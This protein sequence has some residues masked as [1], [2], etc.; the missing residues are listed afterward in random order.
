[1]LVEKDT[2]YLLHSKPYRENSL[3][4]YVLTEQHGKVSFVV[5]GVKSTRAGKS[6][7][8]SSKTALLQPCRPLTLSYR[9]KD[10]LST[11][12]SIEL[13]KAGEIPTINHFM[14]YQY[15]HELLLTLLPQHHSAAMI[16]SAYENFLRDLCNE[17]PHGAL[18]LLE[19]SILD[20]F[21]GLESLYSTP[22]LQS[23]INV[24]VEYCLDNELGITPLSANSAGARR[25]S[26]ENLSAFN[27]LVNTY[28]SD[29]HSD[30]HVVESHIAE[31]IA[32]GA[33]PV[34]AFFIARLLNGKQLK[35]RN[36]YREL[37]EM[38][39]L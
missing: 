5:N 9:L 16:F 30:P 11:M 14:L 29:L 20:Y 37:Q 13:E 38:K 23:H 2:A 22:T 36:I 25:I 18:R 28:Q 34:S 4:A 12:T 3:L 10:G 19:L 31:T 1:M 7:K 26:G 32:R 35:T 15:A 24:G 21:D 27:H 6:C 33:Q 8:Q 17:Q 39:L